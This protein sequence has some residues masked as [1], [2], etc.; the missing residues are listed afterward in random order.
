MGIIELLLGG[1]A[2]GLLGTVVSQILSIFTAAEARKSKLLEF[3]HEIRLQE[4]Q[5]A[6]LK[7][8][9]ERE[10]LI[11]ESVEAG[12]GYAAALQHDASFGETDKW[13]NNLRALFRPSITALLVLLTATIYFTTSDNLIE[14]TVTDAIIFSTIAAISFWFADRSIAKNVANYRKLPWQ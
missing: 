7:E 4:M 2:T 13:V 14:R 6:S 1:G 10:V 9:T 5:L 12:K 8:E 3:E 11:A